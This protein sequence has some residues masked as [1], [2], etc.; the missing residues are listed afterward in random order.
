MQDILTIA[1][2]L[3]TIL[4]AAFIAIVAIF[5]G[6]KYCDRYS[7]E[8]RTF[9]RELPELGADV[10]DDDDDF[11]FNFDEIERINRCGELI[12]AAAIAPHKP[13]MLSVIKD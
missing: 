4:G 1:I 13:A 6:I 11:N 12:L 5:H 8:Q 7:I 3:T 2:E 9:G 10:P